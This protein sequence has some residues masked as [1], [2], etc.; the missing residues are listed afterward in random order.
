MGFLGTHQK[1]VGHERMTH[2]N[3]HTVTYRSVAAL[4][5]RQKRMWLEVG[6][7]TLY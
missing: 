3:H 6:I 4:V 7:E 2:Q 1:P 5:G